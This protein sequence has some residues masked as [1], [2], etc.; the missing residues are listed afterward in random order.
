MN[1][2]DLG[3]T[4]QKFICDYFNLPIP[5]EAQ[6]QFYANYNEDYVDSLNIKNIVA[7]A[8]NEFGS[9]PKECVTYTSSNNVGEKYNPN[10]FVL[11]NS[12]TLSIRTSKSNDK[13]APRVVGQAGIETFNYHFNQFADKKIENKEEI[14]SIVYNNI[15]K[16]LP[17]FF[18]Y[19]FISDFTIWFQY[20]ADNQLTY[21]IFDKNQFLDLEFSRSN[22]SFT[23]DLDNWTEST[24]LKYKNKSIA[25]IQIHKNRT[26]KFRFIMKTVIEFLKTIALN[27]ETLGI[28]AEKTICDIYNLDFPSHLVNRSSRII[29]SQIKPTIVEAFQNLPK[30]TQY[31]GSEQ[32]ARKAESKSPYDFILDGIFTLSLKTNTGNM[33]C[34]PEVGQPSS[35]TCYL[36]FGHLCDSDEINELSF[37]RMVYSHIDEMLHIY[38]THLFDSDYL[39]WIYQKKDAYFY[40]IF[41]KDY[42]S[43]FKWKK[44]NISFTKENIEDWNESNTVKYNNLSI[45]EFQVHKNRNCYKFRFNLTN[46]VKIMEAQ[47]I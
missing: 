24:T 47:N 17:I 45:G 36:Y 19:L 42:A 27:N 8:F 14:K 40:N 38:A 33:V 35:S 28:T 29:E 18:D 16:M 12:K 26:F 32:G 44:E 13:I 1:N 2:A 25:E 30:P 20:S 3:I 9:I 4:I 5:L 41:K 10:N 37:K 31:T 21:T 43:N 34:P 15:H 6:E 11:A 22:F 7:S 23:R 46:L 39:L